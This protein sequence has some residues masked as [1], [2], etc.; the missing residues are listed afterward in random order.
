MKN[1]LV[2][3]KVLEIVNDIFYSHDMNIEDH[4]C[5]YTKL[6]ASES[7]MIELRNSIIDEFCTHVNVN[8]CTL[9]SLVKQIIKEAQNV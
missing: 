5:I 7:C 8:K 4:D 3:D 9:D 1:S 6:R 2:R